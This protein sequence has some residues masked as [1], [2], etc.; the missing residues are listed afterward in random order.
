[1]NDHDI[2]AL[3]SR[4]NPNRRP[5]SSAAVDVALEDLFNEIVATSRLRGVGPGDA[6]RVAAGG[7]RRPARTVMTAAAAAA[8]VVLGAFGL[9][10]SRDRDPSRGVASGSSA[11]SPT[12]QPADDSISLGSPPMVLLDDTW[13]ID[14]LNQSPDEFEGILTF[15]R[16]DREF[17]PA[18]VLGAGVAISWFTGA[19]DG[20]TEGMIEQAPA[21]ALGLPARVLLQGP[22]PNDVM[23]PD[24]NAM[25][26][27]LVDVAEA[28]IAIQTA[29]ASDRAELDAVLATLQQVD[30]ATFEASLPDSI[31]TPD[32]RE[33]A[34]N[35]ML[36][37]IPPPPAFD[38]GDLGSQPVYNER[39]QLGILVVGPVVCGW[40]DVWFTAQEDGDTEAADAAADAMESSHNWPVLVDMPDGG[41]QDNIWAYADV[42]NGDGYYGSA[43]LA[44][45]DIES[46]FQC[47]WPGVG[48]FQTTVGPGTQTTF[49]PGRQTTSTV[50]PA[51]IHATTTVEPTT[52]S[53]G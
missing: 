13:E 48:S 24:G 18:N 27:V 7:T 26:T 9:A 19:D 3:L 11:E 28:T 42:I 40:M 14:Y 31:I 33:A 47:G 10:L 53:G 21:T 1:M 12:A 30:V 35:Q 36:A 17:D 50:S 41:L 51:T 25:Y 4:A 52:T 22:P 32:Q 38:V 6:R 49:A 37:G 16:A 23:P 43:P 15:R 46:I 39:H 2:D 5:E 8:V 34:V 20:W 45:F 29:A 44:R